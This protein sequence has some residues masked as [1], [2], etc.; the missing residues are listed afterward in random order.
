[1]LPII[2]L[3][4]TDKKLPPVEGELLGVDV[5]Q[6]KKYTLV[7]IHL[8]FRIKTVGWGSAV[9]IGIAILHQ[10]GLLP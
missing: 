7:D 5:N 10:A 9:A 4:T 6:G 1:M 2:S 8:R 3:V